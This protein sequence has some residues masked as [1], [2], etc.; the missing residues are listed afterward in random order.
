MGQRS[1]LVL[2]KRKPLALSGFHLHCRVNLT[3]VWIWLRLVF[4]T[5]KQNKKRRMYDLLKCKKLSAVQLL[6][7]TY[8]AHL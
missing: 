8:A 5:Y 4:R 7:F 3:F 6:T 2:S 1:A